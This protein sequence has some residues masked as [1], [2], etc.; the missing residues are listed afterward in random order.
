MADF[1][2][3]RGDTLPTIRAVLTQK[4]DEGNDGPI[5]LSTALGVDFIMKPKDSGTVKINAAAVIVTPSM[6][7]VRYDWAVADT[8]TTGSLQ[9]EWE[10]TWP[11]PKK[12]TVPT[13][14]YHTIDI[15]ADLDN[16]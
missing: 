5:D 4:D 8:A 3:K 13:A 12:Q 9:A 10:I 7:L 14:S 1:M 15:L 11:G 6:G 2:I 16:A